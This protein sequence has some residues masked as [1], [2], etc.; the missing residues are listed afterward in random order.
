MSLLEKIVWLADFTEPTRD[1]PGVD[2]VRALAQED[3]DLALQTA[4]GMT[5]RFI[6][7]KGAK[8]CGITAD[9]LRYYE[10]TDRR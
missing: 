8:P 9:A 7:E 6:E 3:L 4:L 10:Q 2:E 5:L 1:F